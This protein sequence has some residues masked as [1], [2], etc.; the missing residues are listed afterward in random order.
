LD[1]SNLNIKR[2]KLGMKSPVS[3]NYRKVEEMIATRYREKV[4]SLTDNNLNLNDSIF[5][6]EQASGE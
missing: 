1:L 3:L 5:V 4:Q 2:G 6:G